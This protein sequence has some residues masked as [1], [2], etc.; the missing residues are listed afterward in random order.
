V[1]LA[2][3][4]QLSPNNIRANIQLQFLT[5]R[6]STPVPFRPKHLRQFSEAELE[7]LERLNLNASGPDS[8][9]SPLR[10]SV[11]ANETS[12]TPS[13]LNMESHPQSVQAKKIDIDL[14]EKKAEQGVNG[15][16]ES[17]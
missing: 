10:S 11:T 16:V 9:N 7:A 13:K 5:S 2:Y 6:V 12:T 15:H 1:T 8:P 17:A 4:S 3:H 14:L